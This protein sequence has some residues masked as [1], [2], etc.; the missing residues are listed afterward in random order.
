MDELPG[1]LLKV[2]TSTHLTGTN[3]V[4]SRENFALFQCWWEQALSRTG[5]SNFDLDCDI[6]SE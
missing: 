5:C 1:F 6:D 2:S 4:N 3:E